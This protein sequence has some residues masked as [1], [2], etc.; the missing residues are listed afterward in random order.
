VGSD[1]FSSDVLR[2]IVSKSISTRYAKIVPAGAG[3]VAL[4]VRDAGD[5]VARVEV[6]ETGLVKTSGEGVQIGAVGRI[7]EYPAGY[8]A[9]TNVDRTGYTRIEAGSFRARW[10]GE[11][12]VYGLHLFSGMS[13]RTDPSATA[14]FYLDSHDGSRY[15]NCARLMGGWLDLMRARLGGDLVA[16]R[17]ALRNI[18]QAGLL[19]DSTNTL[20]D[21]SPVTFRGAYWDGVSSVDRD[22]VVFHRMLSTAPESEL[23]LRLAG[24]DYVRVG[25]RGFR[26]DR[27]VFDVGSTVSIGAGATYTLP[28]GVWYVRLGANT[29]AEWYSDVEATWVTLVP[30]GGSGLVVSDGSNARLRNTGAV[31]ESSTVRRVM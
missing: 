4:T 14:P 28:T 27:N 12:G 15:V 6:L 18:V 1:V 2:D 17:V 9:V 24:V 30:A 5:T 10:G 8:L 20:R 19:A 7:T 3:A 25:D 21:S 23:V 29:V 26:V 31:A 22:F 13:V 11:L 16:D